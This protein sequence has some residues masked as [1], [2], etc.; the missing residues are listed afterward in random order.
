M[1]SLPRYLTFTHFAHAYFFHFRER[2]QVKISVGEMPTAKKL[3]NRIPR[4]RDA[5]RATEG[6]GMRRDAFDRVQRLAGFRRL[7]WQ[8]LGTV[9][10]D[11]KGAVRV[12]AECAERAKEPLL[13]RY[14]WLI[15]RY[16]S[17]APS[18]NGVSFVDGKEDIAVERQSTGNDRCVYWLKRFPTLFE[19]C[20]A[21]DLYSRPR[22]LAIL[23]RLWRYCY[24]LLS[25]CASSINTHW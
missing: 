4:I 13:I 18:N 9:R 17:R 15:S 24:D 23:I 11:D 3:A 2:R 6:C 19:P 7:G 20:R 22:A 21:R 25:S 8:G 1:H 5:G 12:I 10:E 16:P 14:P